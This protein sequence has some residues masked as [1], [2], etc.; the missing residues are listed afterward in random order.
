MENL[1]HVIT[2]GQVI[3]EQCQKMTY[4]K[5]QCQRLGDRVLGLVK[6]LEMLQDQGKRSVPSEKLTTVTNRFKAALEEAIGEI[7]KFS[8]KS[9]ICRFLKASQD[10]ILLK[11][12]NKKLNDVWA[13]L[14]LLL[15]VEQRMRVS[16][17]SQG[18]SWAQEDQ[19]DA[20]EDRR[21]FQMLRSDNEKMEASLRRLEINMKEIKE[22][23]RQYLPPK[24]MQ[25]IPQEQI[26]EIK[27]EQL[28]GSPWIL[29]RE[30]KVSTLYKGEYHRAP[31]AIK[32]FKE[33]QAGSVAIVRQTFNNEIKAMKKFESP[34]ILRIFG[35]CIDETVT[36]PQ[37]SIVMEYCELGTL[38]ELLDREKDLTLGKRMVLV[39]GA[40][41]G[42]YRLHH[43]EAPE[44]HQ[45]IRS[46]N[47]LVT[48]GYQVK[49]AGFELRKTQ[50]SISLETTREKTDGV[51]STAY[52]SPQKL[53]NIFYP[54][55]VKSEIYSFGIVLWEIATG[56]IPFEGLNSDEIYELVAV[57]QQQ[58]PLGEDCP[59]ELREIIDECRAHDPSVRPSVDEIL[60]KLSTFTK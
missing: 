42:L 56:K 7:E 12:V 39:L 44:L 3:Y 25:E 34:N 30:N 37:F 38:R 20:D 54:Y 15:H 55:D 6:C 60:K 35:I 33:L 19:Q 48:Q 22:T 50:T 17:I 5:K 14:S 32:V 13:E 53:E 18:A 21:A 16:G 28:S 23:L 1:K 59:S 27:K 47:F 36:P 57:K 45:K 4:C 29:L 58:Q 43:S 11:D 51:K 8:N 40:A 52:L 49:L 46:S 41:R 9:N 10:K 31:V 26:K 24:C 2:L